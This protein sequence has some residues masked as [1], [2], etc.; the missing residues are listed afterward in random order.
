MKKQKKLWNDL[1]TKNVKHLIW[2]SKENPT[3]D[4]F[5]SSGKQDYEKYISKDLLIRQYVPDFG[6]SVILEI[7]CGIGRMTEFMALDFKNVIGVD[8]STNMIRRGKERLSFLKNVDLIEADG[9]SLPI[10][11]DAINFAFSFIVFQHMPDKSVIEKNF[12][13]VHRV[14]KKGCLF[15][16][17]IRGKETKKGMWYTGAHYDL[18]STKEL[19]DKVGFDLIKYEGVGERYFWL[20]LNK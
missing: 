16:V 18:N 10:P 1:A 5:R 12:V 19:C 4:E 20:W 17:Q 11:D 3:D 8:I 6:N 9:E 7:G 2:S 14:L 13:E 15:K